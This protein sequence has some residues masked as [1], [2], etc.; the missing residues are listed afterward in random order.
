MICRFLLGQ[1]DQFFGL[2][3]GES[4][5]FLDEDVLAVLESGFGEFKMGP[6]R[7][8]DGHH[9]NLGQFALSLLSRY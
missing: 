6:D 9:V 4:E 1:V 8:D 5:R 3:A 2:R 7:S